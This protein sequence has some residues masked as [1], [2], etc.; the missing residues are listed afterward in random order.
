MTHAP[1]PSAVRAV[2]VQAIPLSSPH[3]SLPVPRCA[4]MFSAH[5]GRVPG[6]SGARAPALRRSA[7]AVTFSVESAGGAAA[8]SGKI[9]CAHS[10]GAV[11]VQGHFP[12]LP[13][14]PPLVYEARALRWCGARALPEPA[15]IFW[16]QSAA[17]ARCGKIRRARAPLVRSVS[18]TI[19]QVYPS[20]LPSCT[21]RG[22]QKRPGGGF[23][24]KMTR[25]PPPAP[26]AV[27]VADTSQLPPNPL[28]PPTPP[29]SSSIPPPKMKSSLA[30]SSPCKIPMQVIQLL[31]LP[32]QCLLIFPVAIYPSVIVNPPSLFPTPSPLLR[33]RHCAFRTV[34]GPWDAHHLVPPVP[35]L[36][37]AH[38]DRPRSLHP[39]KRP[40]FQS[41]SGTADFFLHQ[42]HLFAP[43]LHTCIHFAPFHS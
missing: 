27:R 43:S 13:F 33:V 40:E 5:G 38:G 23:R 15:A 8:R 3:P 17:R 14:I 18:R 37:R 10:A 4:A 36:F 39:F 30:T 34:K 29:W 12:D 7:C 9:G 19:P 24:G 11:W 2:W 41:D 1:R 6:K 31:L 32:I 16:A 28:P 25:A 21:R 22:A 26:V 20:S 35:P 42:P